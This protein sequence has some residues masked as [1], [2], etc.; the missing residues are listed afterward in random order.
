MSLIKDQF[1]PTPAMR[2]YAIALSKLGND[3]TD[4]E[5]GKKIGI[6]P[7]TISRWKKKSGFSQ[8]LEEELCLLRVPIH[9]LLESVARQNLNKFS[10]W[11]ALAAKHEYLSPSVFE[12]SPQ[13]ADDFSDEKT[14]P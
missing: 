2:I 5:I 7:E 4:R 10:Y 3:T 1:Q 13:D 9:F 12:F 6:A 14:Q 8:W 11:E